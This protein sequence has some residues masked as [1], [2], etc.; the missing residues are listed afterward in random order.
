MTIKRDT[1]GN[2]LPTTENGVDELPISYLLDKYLHPK[3]YM[4]ARQA[5][6]EVDAIDYASIQ[7][8]GNGFTSINIRLKDSKKCSNSI[9]RNTIGCKDLKI[10]REWLLEHGITIEGM[11]FYPDTMDNK[12]MD[13]YEGRWIIK[14]Q[15]PND[16]Q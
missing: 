1:Y 2:L 15:P 3:D 14:E 12:I 4:V 8:F 7:D 11:K 10:Y 16:H 9:D 5:L 13:H 6:V